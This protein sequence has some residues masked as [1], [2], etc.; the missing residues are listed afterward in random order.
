MHNITKKRRFD[1]IKR[2]LFIN[3]FDIL[4]TEVIKWWISISL[5]R[6]SVVETWLK[7]ALSVSEFDHKNSTNNFP[8]LQSFTS[9]QATMKTYSSHPDSLALLPHNTATSTYSE[10]SSSYSSTMHQQQQQSKSDPSSFSS[11]G[12]ARAGGVLYSGRRHLTADVTLP[13][14]LLES[15]VGSQPDNAPSFSVLQHRRSA[16]LPFQASPPPPPRKKNLKKNPLNL[17]FM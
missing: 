8:S 5:T 4:H 10:P 16:L 11:A 14:T 9:S 3:S 1:W 15:P 13:E 6:F 7:A 17:S 2:T 12:A